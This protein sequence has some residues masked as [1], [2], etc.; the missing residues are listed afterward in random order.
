MLLK[1]ITP[2]LNFLNKFYSINGQIIMFWYFF[3]LPSVIFMWLAENDVELWEELEGQR[4]VGGQGQA[5]TRCN[6]LN[7][8]LQGMNQ[9]I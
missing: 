1:Q 2:Y 7:N 4:H 9:S 8:Q 5:H 6:H 3:P